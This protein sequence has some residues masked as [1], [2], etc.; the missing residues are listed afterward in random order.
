MG[1]GQLAVAGNLPIDK[2]LPTYGELTVSADTIMMT[3]NQEGS[4]LLFPSQ[5]KCLG[6]WGG[7]R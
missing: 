7:G 1:W 2:P 3:R 6:F 5:S 4:L